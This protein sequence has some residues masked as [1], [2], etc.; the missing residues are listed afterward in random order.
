MASLCH[1]LPRGRCSRGREHQWLLLRARGSEDDLPVLQEVLG[2]SLHVGHLPT[3][4]CNQL[5]LGLAGH[6]LLSSCHRLP[7]AGLHHRGLARLPGHGDL[8]AAGHSWGSQHQVDRGHLGLSWRDLQLALAG[9]HVLLLLLGLPWHR[10]ARLAWCAADHVLLALL[11]G[12]LGGEDHLTLLPTLAWLE[13]LCGRL[14]YQLAL[15]VEGGHLRVGGVLAWPGVE[16]GLDHLELWLTH[17]LWHHHLLLWL[18]VLLHGRPAS[19]HR[20]LTLG[21]A[22]HLAL[23]HRGRG[24][25]WELALPCH[26]HRHLH[27]GASPSTLVLLHAQLGRALALTFLLIGHP[28]S[29][30][31]PLTANLPSPR[32]LSSPQPALPTQTSVA[33]LGSS[34]LVQVCSSAPLVQ[35]PAPADRQD[36]AFPLPAM[37]TFRC[38]CGLA[39]DYTLF[40]LIAVLMLHSHDDIPN[41]RTGQLHLT[42]AFFCLNCRSQERKW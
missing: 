8:H 15:R 26:R 12:Q 16:A 40:W 17:R 41:H 33:D 9:D 30:V 36:G 42:V 10:L 14:K 7:V 6:L 38:L 2:P 35:S 21:L 31:F 39:I 19:M 27:L 4:H 5:R 1:W 18:P 25:S 29:S 34:R 13:E 24:Q 23:L 37:S 11:W 20:L 28:G 32:R 3:W 22:L